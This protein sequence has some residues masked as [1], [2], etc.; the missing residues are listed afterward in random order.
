MMSRIVSIVAGAEMNAHS[1][2]TCL[3]LDVAWSTRSV[4]RQARSGSCITAA[5]AEDIHKCRAVN[6]HGATVKA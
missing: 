1:I 6:C 3:R 4:T 2:L 5:V